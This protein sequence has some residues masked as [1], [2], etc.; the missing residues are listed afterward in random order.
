MPQLE[1]TTKKATSVWKSPD[2]QREIWEL[3][4][5]YEGK[6]VKA[7]TYSK[8]IATNEWHG[9]VETYEKAGR[10]GSETFV[11]QPP[12]EGGSYG[13]STSSGTSTPSG[14]GFAGGKPSNDPYTMYLSYAKDVMVAL[15]AADKVAGYDDYTDFLDAVS[16][17][18]DIL[19]SKRPDA[20]PTVD[21][22]VAPDDVAEVTEEPVDLGKLSELFPDSEPVT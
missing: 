18:G 21:K 16:A 15:I 22:P 11:K 4:L 1:V 6:P 9:T 3:E 5:D 12:K 10:N 20:E 13:P 2:G 17:G 19:Y 7:K 8:D 14:S